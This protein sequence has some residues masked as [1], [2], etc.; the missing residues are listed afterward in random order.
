[1]EGMCAW[2]IRHR[3]GY[4]A[5]DGYSEDFISDQG[6]EKIVD[7]TSTIVV[8]NNSVRQYDRE[9]WPWMCVP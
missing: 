6:G 3:R 2:C 8:F 7:K 5:V 4:F 9:T 1:M